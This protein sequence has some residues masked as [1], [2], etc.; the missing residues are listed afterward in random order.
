MAP[1]RPQNLYN[2]P[3]AIAADYSRFRVSE[4]L[5]LT[6]HS[7]QAWPDCALSGQLRA[8]HDAAELV[9]DKW[10]HAFEVADA[11]R[12]GYARLLDDAPGRVA[13]GNSTHE[14]VTKWLSALPLRARPRL[15]TTDGEFHSIRRQMD[16]LA[17][18]KLFEI[19]KV[20]AA[21]VRDLSERLAREVNDRTAAVMVSSVQFRSGEIVPNLRA[22]AAA[23]S[24]HGAELLIDAYHHLNIVPFSI[25]RDGLERAYV[26]GGGYKFCQLGEGNAFLRVPADCALRPVI[27]GWFAE[28]D[29][30]EQAPG[31]GVAFSPGPL[32][33][34][35]ATYDPT[36]HYRAAEV[37]AYFE[38]KGLTPDLLREVS[39]HQVR[40]IADRFD[41]LDLDA[42]LITRDRAVR[43][44]T[45]AGFLVLR[46][47]R[48]GI[49]CRVLHDRGVFTDYRGDALRVGPAPYLSDTQIEEAVDRLGQVVKGMRT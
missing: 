22:I 16:R 14:L 19:V 27:T 8:W 43:I 47:P 2:S 7:H 45:I 48:A 15:V 25:E 17:E 11:V 31:T 42:K 24:Q 35:G 34:A 41:A 39:Q 28:F 1:I 4:R 26:T 3:N 5:L 33:F 49:L 30:K 36:S 18:E 13:L 23:C 29:A 20:P 37:F 40:R 6:G 44:E 38:R 9:D 21:P 46:S 10:S 32:R 12:R